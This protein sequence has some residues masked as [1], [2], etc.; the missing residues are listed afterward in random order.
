MNIAIIGSG[1]TAIDYATGFA[2]AGHEVYLASKEGDN[3][4]IRH[5][6]GMF[7][8]IHVCSITEAADI[9]DMIVVATEPEGCA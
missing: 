5:I 9:A 8:H 3:A 1:D 2:C 6:S 4:A 7:E